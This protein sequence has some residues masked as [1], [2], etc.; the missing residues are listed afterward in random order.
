MND[1]IHLEFYNFDL[2]MPY[3]SISL[4]AKTSIGDE[5][6]LKIYSQ[7]KIKEFQY[8]DIANQFDKVIPYIELKEKVWV[9]DSLAKINL[10]INLSALFHFDP[11]KIK[12][13]QIEEGKM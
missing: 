5:G 8:N 11:F 2:T 1:K 4:S 10:D 12:Y 9:Q 3:G 6:E 13:L 7:L